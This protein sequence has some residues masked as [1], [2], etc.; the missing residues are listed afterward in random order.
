MY[1]QALARNQGQLIPYYY[2]TTKVRMPNNEEAHFLIL[3]SIPGETLSTWAD[4][5]EASDDKATLIE[6]LP[7]IASPSPPPALN[8]Y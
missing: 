5:C 7:D 2:G 3:E 6:M 4:N 8:K 1:R